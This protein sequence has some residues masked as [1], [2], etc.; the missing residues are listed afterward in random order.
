MDSRIFRNSSRSTALTGQLPRPP[1]LTGFSIVGEIL[2][3]IDVRPATGELYGLSNQN[4]I[5]K[6]NP[7]T[8][9][10]TQV[11]ATLSRDANGCLQVDRLQSDSRPHPRA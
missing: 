4:N 5:Y 1:P 3:S 2:V 11:G 8:G 6:I 10:R 9:G 7:L